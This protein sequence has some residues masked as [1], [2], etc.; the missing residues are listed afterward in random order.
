MIMLVI[1]LYLSVV[2]GDEEGGKSDEGPLP[3]RMSV[4]SVARQYHPAFVV[5]C[6][7]NGRVP[8]CSAIVRTPGMLLEDG[9]SVPR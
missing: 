3:A 4:Y 5:L 9:P 7:D 2:I 1:L 8:H 6:M